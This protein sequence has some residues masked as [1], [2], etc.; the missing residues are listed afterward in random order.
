MVDN[1]GRRGLAWMS[2][3][4]FRMIQRHTQM[5]MVRRGAGVPLAVFPGRM[6]RKNAGET[7]A[8]RK[9]AFLDDLIALHFADR[10]HPEDCSLAAR[11][12]L[13]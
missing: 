11:F 6:Q 9:P 1:L 10:I 4:E 7:P 12:P 2:Q 5:K 3:Q 13:G 8:P